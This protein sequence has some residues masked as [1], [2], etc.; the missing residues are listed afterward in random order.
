MLLHTHTQISYIH[1]LPIQTYASK[2][3]R[4]KKLTMY[5][6]PEQ[7]FNTISHDSLGVAAFTYQEP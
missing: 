5:Q 2:K 6:I 7:I 1:H 4:L 3:N